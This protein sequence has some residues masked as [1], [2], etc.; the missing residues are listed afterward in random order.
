MA[1]VQYQPK[2]NVCI[3]QD[4]SRTEGDIN[5]S[6]NANRNISS[7]LNFVSLKKKN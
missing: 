6:L 2:P 5:S 4:L 1:V 7:K 3:K